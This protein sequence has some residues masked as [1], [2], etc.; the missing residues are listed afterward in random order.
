M[1]KMGVGPEMPPIIFSVSA[2]SG[3]QCHDKK[4]TNRFCCLRET[5]GERSPKMKKIKNDKAK[6]YS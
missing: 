5:P 3:S 2:T 6:C 4:T 1:G